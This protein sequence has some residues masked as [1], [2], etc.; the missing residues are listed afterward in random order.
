MSVRESAYRARNPFLEQD[1]PAIET[2]AK[3]S[4]PVPG[5]RRER[6]LR[7]QRKIFSEG[8]GERTPKNGYFLSAR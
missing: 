3:A 4:E 2:N 8:R 6:E 5:E 7:M 1:V